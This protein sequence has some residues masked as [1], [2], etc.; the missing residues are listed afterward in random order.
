MQLLTAEELYTQYRS[1]IY[2]YVYLRTK[3]HADAEDL[4]SDIFM[5]VIENLDS[6]DPERASYSTWIFTIARNTVISHIRKL[7]VTEDISEMELADESDSP[8]DETI[9]KERVQKLTAALK[10]MK[11]KDR[12]ILIARYYYDYSFREIGDVMDMTEA[13]ARVNHGRALKKM[14]DAL[15]DDF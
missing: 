1:K 10:G 3:N 13:N 7:R 4:T 15:G 6:F 2:G 12:D 9:M 8:L 11:E 14:R 5:K